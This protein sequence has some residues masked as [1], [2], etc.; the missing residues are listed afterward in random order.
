MRCSP[1][2]L[3]HAPRQCLGGLDIDRVIHG[4]QRLQRRVGGH[5][6]EGAHRARGCI[7]RRHG[8]IRVGPAPVGVEPASVLVLAGTGFPVN[9]TAKGCL[10]AEARLGR[11]H[12][13]TVHLGG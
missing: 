3:N 2:F 5:A 6:F 1:A 13:W 12:R 10:D 7:E 9:T 8:R 4:H 11:L